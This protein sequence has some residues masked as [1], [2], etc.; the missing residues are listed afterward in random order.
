MAEPTIDEVPLGERPRERPRWRHSA[1]VT[2]SIAA[3]AVVFAIT[4]PDARA[5]VIEVSVAV[6]LAADGTAAVPPK[7]VE[8]RLV[9][10]RPTTVLPG[11][12]GNWHFDVESGAAVPGAAGAGD[13]SRRPGSSRPNLTFNID[14]RDPRVLQWVERITEIAPDGITPRETVREVARVVLT[15]DGLSLYADLSVVPNAVRLEDLGQVSLRDRDSSRRVTLLITPLPT[16][17]LSAVFILDASGSMAG[18]R[19]ETARLALLDLLAELPPR[20]EASLFV[21]YD[22]TEITHV[23]PFT[24][25]RDIVRRAVAQV[26]ARGG[27][28]LGDAIAQARAYLERHARFP[29]GDRHLY[30]LT[31]GLHNCGIDPKDA[32]KDFNADDKGPRLRIVAFDMPARE[33][34]VLEELAESV[35][36]TVESSNETQERRE[37]PPPMRRK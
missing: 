27:T 16:T 35:G 22:C 19:I 24:T 34:R 12:T 9:P 10:G 13:S 4:I 29:M 26:Q 5:A 2:M 23:V 36:G 3:L 32:L 21:F 31:D 18:R 7:A 6:D 20:S 11:G 28:P 1:I 14:P 15:D 37:Q 33:V 8:V 17:P 25:D 30:V